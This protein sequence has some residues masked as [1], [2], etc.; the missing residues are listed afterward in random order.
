MKLKRIA[1]LVASVAVLAAAQP[2]AAAGT[3]AGTDI[4][5]TATVTYSVGGVSQPSVNSNTNTFKVDRRIN[6]TVA[7]V[8]GAYVDVAPGATNQALTFTV[9]NLTNDTVDFR[10]TYTQDTTGTADPFGGTDDFNTSNVRF[11]LDNGDSVFN[12]ATDTLITFLDNIPADATRRVYVVSDMPAGQPNNDTSSGTLT[13]IASTDGSNAANDYTQ[14]AGADTPGVVDTVFGDGAG[15]TDAARDGRHS[16]DGAYRIVAAT[17]TVTK[18][19]KIVSDPFNGAV[20]PKAIPG[21]VL[22]Y[23]IQVTNSGSTSATNVVVNDSVPANTTFVAGSIFAGGSVTAGVCNADGTAEDDNNIGAD[24]T[25]PNGGSFSAGTV[26]TMVPSVAA[27]ATTASR[28]RVTI[29]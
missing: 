26:S 1:F 19:V 20:N 29:N 24:E 27:A 13:A 2:A 25:D 23:C 7:E 11:Y 9:T 8:G 12:I 22:E 5:N 21:A 16:D 18:T 6:V 28:F 15:D 17:I 14:T 10:L 4:T 3:A